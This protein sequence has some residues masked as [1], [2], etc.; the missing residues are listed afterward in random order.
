MKY[1]DDPFHA[2]IQVSMVLDESKKLWQKEHDAEMVANNSSNEISQ[3]VLKEVIFHLPFF[4]LRKFG[5]KRSI[6][7]IKFRECFEILIF[8]S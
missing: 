1:I 2:L 4:M 5:K 7:G 6:D 3:S 8:K